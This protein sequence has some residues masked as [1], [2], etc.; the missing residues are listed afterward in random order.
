MI[1]GHMSS[2]KAYI[3]YNLTMVYP[4]HIKQEEYVLQKRCKVYDTKSGLK[5]DILKESKSNNKS[6]E[7]PSNK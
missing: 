3:Y 6:Y 5:E 4:N 2:S 1:R 7:W